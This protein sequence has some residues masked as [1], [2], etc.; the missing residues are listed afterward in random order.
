MTTKIQFAILCALG[1]L[2]PYEVISQESKGAKEIIIIE[3]VVD[4]EGNIISKNT[5]R[6][7]GDYSDEKINELLEEGDYPSTRSY[8]LE[9]LGFE[10]NLESLFGRKN[11]RPTLGIIL[12]LDNN[13]TIVDR[14]LPGSGAA[15]ADVRKGD[16][17]ISINR[18]AVSTLE[19]IH[20][21]LD[22]RAVGDKIDVLIVRDGQE[23]E[24]TVVLGSGGNSGAFFDFPSTGDFRLFGESDGLPF[25]IDSLFRNFSDIDDLWNG[26]GGLNERN[27]FERGGIIADEDRP[28]LGVFISDSQTEVLIESVI[29]NS[30]AAL[31][32]LK[33]GDVILRLDDN[34]VS[35]F[36]EVQSI[37]N[38]KKKGDQLNVEIERKGVKENL[39]ISL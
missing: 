19:D 21:I 10:D 15:S 16:E 35:S 38:T 23:Y 39:T 4:E 7:S 13:R 3:K 34:I 20:E 37:M 32:G 9:G 28:S 1:L 12:T 31:G 8:D 2:L 18:I 17:I 11:Q 5:K 14:V 26:F 36:R 27:Q 25:D 30:P 29:E 24:K 33:E 6:Y 22:T